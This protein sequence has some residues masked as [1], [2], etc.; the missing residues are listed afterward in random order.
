VDFWT[1]LVDRVLV[2]PYVANLGLTGRKTGDM[3]DQNPGIERWPCP[4]FWKRVTINTEG[5][6]QFCVVDWTSAS[7]MVHISQSSIADIWASPEYDRM[8]GC[9]LKKQYGE[10]HPICGPCTDW[11][12]MR[13]DWGFDVAIRAA[14]GSEIPATPPRLEES[15]SQT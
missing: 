3:V 10:A 14:L 4:Q 1:P 11:M 15:H 8:R 9:H 5:Y 12:G 7:Q 13:W 6:I 2:R